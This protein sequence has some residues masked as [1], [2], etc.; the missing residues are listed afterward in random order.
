[1]TTLTKPRIESLDLLKGKF[2]VFFST[3][4]R[5]PFFFN[6]GHLYLLHSAAVICA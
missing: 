1:M 5:I 4:G 3:F 2:V 6:I